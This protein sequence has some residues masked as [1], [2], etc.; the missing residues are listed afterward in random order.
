MTQR[1]LTIEPDD[2]FEG[3]GLLA[4]GSA[5][6]GAA[7]ERTEESVEHWCGMSRQEVL[8]QL[9]R[10]LQ[11]GA[12]LVQQAKAAESISV[13]RR[14]WFA[15]R[16]QARTL[17]ALTAHCEALAAFLQAERDSAV[18]DHSFS[19][20]EFHMLAEL[21]SSDRN[22]G[23]AVQELAGRMRAVRG[24]AE[25]W[26]TRGKAELMQVLRREPGM[27]FPS[28]QEESDMDE[29]LQ[30]LSAFA[31]MVTETGRLSTRLS[32]LLERYPS[33]SPLS[34]AFAAAWTAARTTEAFT[35]DSI[36]SELEALQRCIEGAS[37]LAEESI[38]RIRSNRTALQMR[39]S[40][41]NSVAP[42]E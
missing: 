31:E 10:A 42:A 12:P 35:S 25:N 24:E 11:P 19:V 34:D 23:A 20:D 16:G 2:V 5:A 36:L 30:K 26:S 29:S 4:V 21:L 39:M 17:A 28:S 1:A 8:F 14:P 6:A 32:R 7:E 33:A 18:A 38:E 9:R 15:S 13:T 37:A 40:A 27:P 3:E 22:G 41:A